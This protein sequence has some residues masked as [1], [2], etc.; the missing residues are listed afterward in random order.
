M[1]SRIESVSLLEILK[2]LSEKLKTGTTVIFSP[3]ILYGTDLIL[4]TLVL[5]RARSYLETEW[6]IH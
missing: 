6:P 1:S 3:L 4:L 5:V 2:P